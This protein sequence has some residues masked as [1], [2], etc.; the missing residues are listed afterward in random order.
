MP[1]NPDAKNSGLLF[2]NY[3]YG[4]YRD[5]F[6]IHMR[7]DQLHIE[8]VIPISSENLVSFLCL[9]PAPDCDSV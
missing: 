7:Q 2:L 3:I 6:T 1:Q 4:K 8:L 5:T 9:E